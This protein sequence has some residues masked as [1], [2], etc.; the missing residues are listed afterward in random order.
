MKTQAVQ[1]SEMEK[2]L[3]QPETSAS[4]TAAGDGGDGGGDGD[5][6]EVSA[7]A[8]ADGDGGDGG[9]DGD[10]DGGEASASTAAGGDEDGGG[11]GKAPDQA[12]PKLQVNK[13]YEI[14]VLMDDNVAMHG[15]IYSKC[16]ICMKIDFTIIYAA[17]V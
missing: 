5:D 13:N 15:Y 8:T 3:I 16:Q 17:S 10:G 7:S 1:L 6:G 11:D 14:R 12:S 4:A 9:G 2:A